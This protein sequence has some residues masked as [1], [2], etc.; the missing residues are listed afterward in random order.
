MANPNPLQNNQAALRANNF[1]NISPERRAEIQRKGGIESA[2]RRRERFL[3]TQ[4]MLNILAAPEIGADGLIV[5]D[6]EGNVITKF[7]AALLRTFD[8]FNA[9]LVPDSNGI[10]K[11]ETPSSVRTMLHSLLI[12]QEIAGQRNMKTHTYDDEESPLVKLMIAT[13]EHVPLPGGASL[14]QNIPEEEEYIYDT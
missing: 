12:L 8:A 11:V 5:L 6:D 14:P 3:T 10:T 4:A 1:A 9:L 2:R 7:E 13:L